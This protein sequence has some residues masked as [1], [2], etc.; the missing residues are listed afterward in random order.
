[1]RSN[2]IVALLL[3]VATTAA[4]AQSPLPTLEERMSQSDFHATGLDK[5]SPA[6]L[7][8][9]NTWVQAH[10][11]GGTPQYV[12]PGGA[13]VFYPHDAA[14]DTIEAHIDGTFYGWRGKTVFKLDNGQEWQQAES[15]V[16]DAGKVDNPGVRIQPMLLGSWLMYID[17]CGCN[18]R[19]N[20]IR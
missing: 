16:F 20:R 8:R 1:M 3:L 14:R 6:E 4:L 18:V 9:L 11:G 19:V 2:P 10:G 13:P 15:G 7:G 12:T 5:L 17:R